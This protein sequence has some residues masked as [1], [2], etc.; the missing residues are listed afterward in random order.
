[1]KTQTFLNILG[2]YNKAAHAI[3]L[4]TDFDQL[5]NPG[6]L[7]C[8]EADILSMNPQFEKTFKQLSQSDKITVLLGYPEPRIKRAI[9]M[10]H[11]T[12]ING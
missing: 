1:M 8:L 3:W 6:I 12:F 7:G 11:W 4:K 5:K 2:P 9:G 10:I